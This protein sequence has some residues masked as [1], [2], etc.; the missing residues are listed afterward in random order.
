[1]IE[2]ERLWTK[3]VDGYICC[4]FGV[5]PCTDA[6]EVW[7][8][9]EGGW[10]PFEP[11]QAFATFEAAKSAALTELAKTSHDPSAFGSIRLAEF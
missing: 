11:L 5:F 8:Y 6:W 2:T 1:M 7:H 4:G 3:H 10:R 9:H